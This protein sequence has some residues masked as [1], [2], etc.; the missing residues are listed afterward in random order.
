MLL[1]NS[2]KLPILTPIEGSMGLR[3][4]TGFEGFLWSFEDGDWPFR[5]MLIG[6]SSKSVDED[7]EVLDWEE[8]EEEESDSICI[9]GC[10]EEIL[11][12]D[13]DPGAISRFSA[14]AVTSA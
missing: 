12:K 8:D 5:R 13:S 7:D 3:G 11:D 10:V 4:E 1:F 9:N 14:S 6:I 2:S